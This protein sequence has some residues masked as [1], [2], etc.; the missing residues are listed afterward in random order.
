VLTKAFVSARDGDLH[1]RAAVS[2]V[3]DAG[4]PMRDVTRDI[5][6]EPRD[7]TPDVGAD[8]F[9]KSNERPR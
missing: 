3:V 7:A 5:D 2:G 6:N 4:E 1:L 9:K 8:E